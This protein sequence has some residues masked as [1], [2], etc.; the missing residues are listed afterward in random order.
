MAGFTPEQQQRRAQLYQQLKEI[1][2]ELEDTTAE[3]KEY[4]ARERE[5]IKQANG[6]T[7]VCF[8]WGYFLG[9]IFWGYFFLLLKLRTWPTWTL[10][11]IFR[12]SMRH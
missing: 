12:I 4:E 8:C 11:A 1:E 3:R 7:E 6:I 9:V 10:N 2:S 5:L